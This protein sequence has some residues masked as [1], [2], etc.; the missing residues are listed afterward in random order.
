MSARHMINQALEQEESRRKR[1]FLSYLASVG[2]K[3]RHQSDTIYRH[4]IS[5]DDRGRQGTLTIDLTGREREAKSHYSADHFARQVRTGKLVDRR[6]SHP[7]RRDGCSRHRCPSSG[8][9]L[10]PRAL[11]R[12]TEHYTD[13]VATSECLHD[14]LDAPSACHGGCVMMQPYRERRGCDER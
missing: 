14:C 13:G 12:D 11:R 4:A 10:T 9:T 5:A 7:E 1:A 8:R 3:A 2:P 6:G